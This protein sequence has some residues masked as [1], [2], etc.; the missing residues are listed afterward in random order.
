MTWIVNPPPTVLVLWW[1][2]VGLTV[3]VVVPLAVYLLHR[4][5]RAARN[6]RRY[7]EA[8]LEAGLGIAG[9]TGRIPALDDTIAGA[10][11]LLER[12][13]AIHELTTTVT[14]VLRRR[15]GLEA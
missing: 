13:A 7:S 3:A 6:I 4:T 2:A 10:G 12:A 15:A 9:N 11:P 5:W 8:A 14:R 1:I